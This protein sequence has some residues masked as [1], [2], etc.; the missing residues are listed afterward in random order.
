MCKGPWSKHRE[1]VTNVIGV[2]N[3]AKDVTRKPV[4]MDLKRGVRVDLED[5]GLPRKSY[6]ERVHCYE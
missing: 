1:G 6:P 2:W 4:E 5:K 3:G